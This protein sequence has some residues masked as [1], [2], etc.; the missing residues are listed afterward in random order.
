MAL[1][2]L[3]TRRREG[4]VAA[5]TLLCTVGV[6]V[7]VAALVLALALMDGLHGDI[8]ARLLSSNPHVVVRPARVGVR[9]DAA[10]VESITRRALE[11]PGVVAAAPFTTEWGLLRSDM[12][13]G[14]VPV[15][16]KGIIPEAEDRV[17]GLSQ[18]AT[19]LG[20]QRLLADGQPAPGRAVVPAP[21]DRAE[22]GGDDPL[23]DE[24]LAAP[25]PPAVLLGEG[26]ARQLGVVPGDVVRLLSSRAEMSALGPSQR[27]RAFVV[28]G[29]LRT[30]L[31][32]YDESWGVVDLRRLSPASEGGAEGVAL[33]L[34]EAL[35]APLIAARLRVALG[36][37]HDVTEWTTTFGRLFAAFKWER[38]LMVIAVGLIGLVAGFNIFTILTLNVTARVADI[39]ILSAL[40]ASARSISGIFLWMGVLLGG[41]GTLA[42]LAGGAA[43]ARLLDA[44]QLIR[45]DA[46]VYLVEHVPFTVD[47]SDL[48]VVAAGMLA[49]SLIATLAPARAAARLD[50]VVALRN[51]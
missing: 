48:A 33:A 4:P 22:D 8:R 24:D 7:G 40:G 44:R 28:G 45:L 26:L 41:G 10:A 39:G 37:D 35:D 14:G 47:P 19:R 2:Y 46:S 3:V 42:G 27:S 29:L 25:A 18:Q 51:A 20:W 38:L 13:P 9:H 11:Q 16:L 43:I 12:V 32:E 36:D 17:T 23:T 49:V 5:V 6:T 31:H 21:G 30:G 15:Q 50:P 1:R 34:D